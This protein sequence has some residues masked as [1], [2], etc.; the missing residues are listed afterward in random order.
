MVRQWQ[1]M[2]YDK[3]YESTYLVNPDFVRLAA[4]YGIPALRVRQPEETRAAIA[5]A[6]KETGPALIEFEVAREGEEGNVYPIVPPGA[7][8]HEMVRLPEPCAELAGP[9]EAQR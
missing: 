5:A 1:E 8:L 9:L 7:A 3:R 6:R 4:A 2:F